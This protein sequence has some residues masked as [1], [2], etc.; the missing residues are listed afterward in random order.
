MAEISAWV[1]ITRGR[2]SRCF[3]SLTHFSPATK[4]VYMAEKFNPEIGFSSDQGVSSSASSDRG[5]DNGA[6]CN[7]PAPPTKS[8]RYIRV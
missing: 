1:A 6:A 2:V 8:C 7:H 4:T 3:L 5:E